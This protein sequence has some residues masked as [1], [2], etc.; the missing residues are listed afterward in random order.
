MFS[1]LGDLSD[2]CER[3]FFASI[4]SGLGYMDSLLN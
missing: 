4:C 3:Y 1:F 2:L